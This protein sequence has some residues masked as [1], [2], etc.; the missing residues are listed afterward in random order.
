MP[1]VP[2]TLRAGTR[3]LP[4]VPPYVQYLI[5]CFLAP[6]LAWLTTLVYRQVLSRCADHPLVQIAQHY[7]LRA[8]VTACAAYHHR[9]GPGAPPT[10]S[11][12]QLV[13]AELVRAW[14]SSCTDPE[15][16]WL[17]ASNLVVR[18]FVGLPL[19]G[20]TPDHSTLNRFH[21]WMATTTPAALFADVAAFLDQIDPEPAATTPQIVDTFAMASPAAPT[22][23]VIHLLGHLLIRLVAAWPPSFPMPAVLATLDLPIL[24]H[25]PRWHT[26]DERQQHL[27][28]VVSTAQQVL[29][30]ATPVLAPRSDSEPTLLDVLLQAI[31]K[32]IADETATDATGRIS[33]RPPDD[34]GTY[35]CQSAVDLQA[36]FRKHE[37]SPAV[38]G[39]NAVISTTATRIRAAIALT[40]STPD[41]ETP[42]AV[43]RQLQAA[44][45]PLPPYLIMD[46]AGGRGPTRAQVDVLSAGQTQMVAL[47]PPSGGSDPRRF[48]V[49][50]FRFNRTQTSCICPNGVVSTRVYAHGSNDGVF[51]RFLARQCRDCPFWAQCRDPQANPKGHRTVFIS[52]YH[53]YLREAEAFNHSVLGQQLLKGRWRVEPTI[54]WLVRY[55]GCRQSRRV[56]L[57]AAQFQ[58]YQACA[59]RN[60][61]LWLSRRRRQADL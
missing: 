33:E 43:V 38:F 53:A 27:Q 18:A 56:G 10:F 29:A 48:T 9:S 37:G 20:P 41:C 12:D 42:T 52:T 21:A 49:A 32:V 28:R 59:V 1:I 8:V 17:L 57:V 4:D 2:S 50:D 45:V 16:E 24:R 19:V 6:I 61:L 5:G 40:G 36:T 34:K 35:R 60:L 13:R 14:A 22:V 51:F 26:A 7:N 47:I 31:G 54:A 30:A 39:V 58:L 23:S 46:Q 25:P 44:E 55:H 3:D 15:L 11:V